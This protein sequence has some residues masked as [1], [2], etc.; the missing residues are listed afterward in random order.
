M[1]QIEIYKK[2]KQLRKERGLTLNTFAEK[3]GSDY[4]QVSRIERGKSKLTIDML[5]RMADALET[6]VGD[7]VERPLSGEKKIIPLKTLETPTF[8]SQELLALILGNLEIM[9]EK[10]NFSITPLTK[11]TL[12]TEIYQQSLQLYR[13]KNQKEEALQF[14]EHSINLVKIIKQDKNGN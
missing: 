8:F 13:E 10:S 6:P 4:Q 1:S 12:A 9:L 14:I 5:M 3:I 11:A 2:L 7:I